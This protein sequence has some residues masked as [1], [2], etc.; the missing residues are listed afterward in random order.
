[1]G[2]W[3]LFVLE[4]CMLI[5]R[6]ETREGIPYGYIAFFCYWYFNIGYIWKYSTRGKKWIKRDF[7]AV[8]II[9]VLVLT[10]GVVSY[11]YNDQ[12]T[13]QMNKCYQMF[14]R[15]SDAIKQGSE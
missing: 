12:S 6:G 13:K 4:C 8:G 2:Y 14:E 9:F 11:K 5:F 10:L 1:M 3:H 7:I 15:F